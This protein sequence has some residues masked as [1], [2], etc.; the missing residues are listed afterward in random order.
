MS[1]SLAVL[2]KPDLTLGLS[3]PTFIEITKSEHQHGGTGWEFGTC[4]WSPTKNRAGSDRY[5]IM[6]EPGTG[7]RVIHVYHT[8]HGG[9]T[10]TYIIGRSEVKRRFCEVKEEPPS[11]GSWAG[12][13]PYYRIDVQNYSQF[14]APLPIRSFIAD[15]GDDIRADL[16]ENEPDFYPFT[17]HGDDIRTV[18]GIYLARC[19]EILTRLLEQA[20][21]IEAATGASYQPPMHGDYAEARRMACE[22]YFFARNPSLVREAKKKYGYRC[23]VCQ[24][25]FSERYLEVGDEFIEVHHL[26]QLSERPELTWT[27]ELRTSINRVTVVCSNCHRMLHRRRPAYKLDDL[28]SRLLNTTQTQAEPNAAADPLPKAGADC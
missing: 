3:M 7:D 26:D 11:P 13:S 5:S 8:E 2:R 14:E 20:L 18:Q 6:R 22:R 10:D 1:N 12:M 17:T 15:Y 4:L 9:R 19:T 23:Q 21:G 24:F 28:R 27:D 25:C 16:I